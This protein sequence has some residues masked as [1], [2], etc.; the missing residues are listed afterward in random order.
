M[1]LRPDQFK[2]MLPV[3]VSVITTVDLRGT[4]NAAPYGCLMPVLRPLDII[5]VASALPRDTLRNIRET[6]QF[7]VNVMGRPSFVEAMRTARNYPPG[8]SELEEEGIET[9]PS[10][11]VDPPR[12]SDALGWIEVVLDREITGENYSLAIGKV[13]CA[14]I[15]DSYVDDE[16]LSESPIVMLSPDYRQLGERI[17]DVRDT[18]KLFLDTEEPNE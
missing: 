1:E 17:G 5:A 8:V 10:R 4:A 7:V 16:K 9:S 2:R 13:V 18:M 14:E 6:G 12:I 15:N 11:E 3:P